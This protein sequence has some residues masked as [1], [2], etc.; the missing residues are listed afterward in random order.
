MIVYVDDESKIRAVGTTDD[1]TLTPLVINDEGNPFE[2]WSR[3]KICCY[4]VTVV[5]GVVTMMTPYIDSRLLEG[6]DMI[7]HQI[8]ADGA[9]VVKK[10]AYI[11]DTEVVFKGAPEGSIRIAFSDPS[12]AYTTTKDDNGITVTFQ[13]LEEV[14]EVTLSIQ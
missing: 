10:T 9:Y 5:D 6:I 7:G 4:K 13:P 11:D 1:K 3:A 14:T 2:G 12:V 8:D